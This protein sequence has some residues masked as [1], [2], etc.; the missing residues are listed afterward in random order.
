LKHLSAN[1]YILDI[2][3]HNGKLISIQLYNPKNDYH[4]NLRD[5]YL[6]LPSSLK[7]LAKSF[8]AST[9][10][11][12]FP[13]LF[14][15]INHYGQILDKKFFPNI[16]EIEYQELFEKWN[17][18][19]WSFKEESIKYC[20]KDC[21]SLYQVLIAFNTIIFNLFS[22]NINNY[23]TLPSLAFGIY[24]IK[25]L[26]L[27]TEIHIPGLAGQNFKDIKQ[28]YTRGAVDMY[29]PKPPEGTK[30]FGYDVN[31]LYPSQML[32][33]DVPV[34]NPTYFEGDIVKYN[35]SAFGFFYCEVTTPDK[36]EHPIIQIHHDTGTRTVAP[37]GKFEFMLILRGNS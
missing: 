36:L 25:Y 8:N 3:R 28:S 9:Q 14:N 23:P 20:L 35:P 33:N 4:L 22:T 29:I 21:I 32:L 31:S 15:D 37:L 6:M 30:I 7:K 13:V 18:K 11:D 2:T 5:S 19:V 24:R 34:G 16:S 17:N 10:K 12:L 26:S 27:M 1:D